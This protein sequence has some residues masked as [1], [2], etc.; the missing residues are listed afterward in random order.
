MTVTLGTKTL[1]CVEI[2]VNAEP[3]TVEKPLFEGGKLT[4][5][6]HVLGLKHVWTLECVEKDVVWADSAAKYAEEQAQAGNIVQLTIDEGNRY[7]LPA[8]NV[9]VVNV[10]YR[11]DLVGATNIRRFAITVKEA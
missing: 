7:S 3:E 10:D 2:A 9:Y 4:V 6:R 8:T 11:L 5:K 1:N